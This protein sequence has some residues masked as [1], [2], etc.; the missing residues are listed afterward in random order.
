M[1]PFRGND[2]PTLGVEE[3]FHL[4][5]PGTGDL[6]GCVEEVLALL[7][8]EMRQRVCY[9]LFDCVIENRT[10][11]FR[12]AAD[13]TGAVLDG[14]RRIAAACAQAGALLVATGSHPFGNHR[15][16]TVAADP[17]YHDVVRRYGLVARRLLAFGLHVHVGLQSAEAAIDVLASMRPWVY[18]LLAL[19]VN[20]PFLAGEDT[21]LCSC[22]TDLF[23]SMPRTYLPPRF[24]YWQQLERHYEIM[25]RAGDVTA[26]GELWWS[27][28]PQPPL[29]T[30]ELRATDLPTDVHRIG[31][32]AAV[33]QAAAHH[34]QEEY[35]AGES[36]PVCSEEYL[37]QNRWRACSDG[38]DA[39]FVNPVSGEVIPVREYLDGFLDT[40]EP[41][42]A[43]L[44]GLPYLRYARDMIR[45]D[46]EADRQRKRV[47]ELDGDLATLELELAEKTSSVEDTQYPQL[48]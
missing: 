34:F 13:L 39:L 4:V 11:V 8:D 40:I 38:L 28:R 14:R 15:N 26:P 31:A 21:G 22:R 37:R 9:E 30:V 46:T 2:Y 45:G 23:S 16:L 1:K 32:I 17:H 7:D 48:S 3:E 47:G 36:P 18:A 12:T 6:K 43:D 20:S 27:I 35:A 5:D 24:T 33:F 29:G 25:H 42:A 44:D 10:G 41:A 19:S